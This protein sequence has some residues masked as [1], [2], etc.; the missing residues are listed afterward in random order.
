M[1][2]NKGLTKSDPRV[3]KYGNTYSKKYKGKP[4]RILT[5]EEKER[6]RKTILEKIKNGT[7]HNSFARARTHK[8]NGMNFYGKWELAYAKYLDANNIN[9]RQPRECFK[10]IFENKEHYYHPDFYLIDENLYIE[11]KGYK[12][13]KDEAKWNQFPL[14]LKV[15]TG[16]ELKELNLIEDYK[17]LV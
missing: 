14:K 12:T 5:L 3:A 1:V 2:W 16:K 10:Y 7:W 13:K 8:Y 4:G 11:V 15:L 17:I 9:W 6:T